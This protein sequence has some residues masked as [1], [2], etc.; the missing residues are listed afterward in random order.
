MI[1]TKTEISSDFYQ[2][3]VA[4]KLRICE[5]L[6]LHQ[7]PALLARSFDIFLILQRYVDDPVILKA[8]LLC[9]IFEK[10]HLCG[11]PNIS[12]DHIYQQIH[13]DF[14]SDVA[15]LIKE[16]SEEY[17]I[18]EFDERKQN[19]LTR[20]TDMS[21]KAKWLVVV[22]AISDLGFFNVD[23]L[24]ETQRIVKEFNTDITA[25]KKYYKTLF[26]LMTSY[27][28]A[29]INSEYNEKMRVVKFN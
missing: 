16:S 24:G 23:I 15:E 28:R 17:A 5:N 21:E 18:P 13:G 2:R 20:F 12:K 9:D 7:D 25:Y 8:S 26:V 6:G 29:E 19:V 27:F 1:T 10:A 11:L 14:G 3:I 22:K 4:K